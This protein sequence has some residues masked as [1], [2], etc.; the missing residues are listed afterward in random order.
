[1]QL[2]RAAIEREFRQEWRRED[3]AEAL[4]DARRS[5]AALLDCDAA[6][7]AITQSAS[8]AANAIVNGLAWRPGDNVV[9]TDVDY[10]S[11]PL[12][13]FR[14]RDERG[15]AVRMVRAQGWQLD[16]QAVLAAVDQRTRLVIVPVLPTFCGVLQPVEEIG[17]RLQGTTA[18]DAVNATQAV[19]QIALSVRRSGAISCSEPVASGCEALADWGSC[20]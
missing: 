11:T 20:S 9:W 8:Y 14:L 5:L 6:E 18:L 19:G 1:M 3:D 2:F 15:V 12:A 16:P 7:M 13:L 10:R 17:A 4:L